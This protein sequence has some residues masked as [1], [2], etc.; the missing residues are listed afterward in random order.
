MIEREEPRSGSGSPLFDYREQSMSLLQIA[1]QCLRKKMAAA[2]SLMFMFYNPHF[3]PPIGEEQCNFKSRVNWGRFAM[4]GWCVM[5]G[6]VMG[7]VLERVV[8][9]GRCVMG[10][11]L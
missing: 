7:G 5:G 1:S 10:G 8:C 3:S 6:C 2:Q 11:V 4:R 9:Y